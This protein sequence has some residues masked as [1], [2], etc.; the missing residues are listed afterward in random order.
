MQSQECARCKAHAHVA[1]RL[2]PVS[3][4]EPAALRALRDGSFGH[5]HARHAS[6][7]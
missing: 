2:E 4:L 1:V 3:A 6:L 7:R 5:Q